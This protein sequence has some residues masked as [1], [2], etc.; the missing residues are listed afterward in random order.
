MSA[1]SW[2][3]SS[4]WDRSETVVARDASVVVGF[5]SGVHYVH[6]DKSPELWINEVGVAR[7]HCRYSGP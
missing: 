5:A 3:L 4:A 2:R 7:S 1:R 6:P